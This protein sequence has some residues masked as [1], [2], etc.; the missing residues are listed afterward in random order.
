MFILY[1][2]SKWIKWMV[3][4]NEIRCNIEYELIESLFFD[5]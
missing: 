5:G 4:K 2:E 3:D 1:V